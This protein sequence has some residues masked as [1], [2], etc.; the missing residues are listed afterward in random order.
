MVLVHGW[1]VTE[2]HWRHLL[3]LLNQAGFDTVPITLPGLGGGFDQV[4]GFRKVDIA[5]WLGRE[6][7]RRGIS[8]FSLIGHDW[9]AT[10]G[11]LLAAEVGPALIALV[12][13]EELL[14][15]IDIEL[16]APGRDHYPTW[17]GPFNRAV[18]LA[19]SLVP[20]R[21]SV[22]YGAFLQQSAGPAGLDPHTIRSYIDAYGL[23][24]ALRAGLGY[25]RSRVDDVRGVETL[26]TKPLATPTL[27][28][29][30]RFAMGSA[31]ADGMRA[32]ACDVTGIV[33]DRSG[34]YPLEQEPVLIGHTVVELLR[35]H[36]ST[37]VR[38]RY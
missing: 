35:Q 18:G 30:G 25:Y 8:R 38:H 29:G 36:T 24:A 20:G 15:G 4:S 37:T 14:P 11:A 33:A 13:E 28:I 10:V 26:I 12:V 21:E 23:P 1:P 31:V 32:V 16:P 6:L 19:E 34:H 17:H 9:G 3:P 2:A 22:Y 27:A 7:A 5:R